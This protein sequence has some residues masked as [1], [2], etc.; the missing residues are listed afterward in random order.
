MKVLWRK[1]AV[2][3][4][5]ELDRWRE[6][7]DLDPIADYI[8]HT[9]EMYFGKQDFS[10]YTPG[11]Q[12][13]IQA[14]PVE[15]RMVLIAIGNSSPLNN[16]AI[17]SLPTMKGVMLMFTLNFHEGR[18]VTYGISANLMKGRHHI[19]KRRKNRTQSGNKRG[20][21]KSVQMAE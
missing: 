17:L 13:F 2:E 14:I 19:V 15:L 18:R 1:S 10:I 11:R 9:V 20:L 16:Y 21:E 3:S 5:M 6:S 7:I 4:L 8:I 12:V